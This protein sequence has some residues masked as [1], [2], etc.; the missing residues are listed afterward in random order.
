MIIGNTCLYGA[1]GGEL[2]AAGLMP[3]NDF[4]VRNSG[5]LAVVE[6]AGRSLLP[7]T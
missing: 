4:A 1:T 2:F 7:N 5:A 6:G 3:G